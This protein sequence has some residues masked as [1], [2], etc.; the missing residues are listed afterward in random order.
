MFYLSDSSCGDPFRLLANYFL[1]S[2][3]YN[4]DAKRWFQRPNAKSG[5]D[6]RSV[7]K[8]QIAYYPS[9]FYFSQH[10]LEFLSCIMSKLFHS[11]ER[12][13]SAVGT[14]QWPVQCNNIF[15][16]PLNPSLLQ[17]NTKVWENKVIN[18]NIIINFVSNIV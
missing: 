7:G 6:S 4:S 5:E 13:Y 8:L 3:V 17:Y 16:Q 12:S 9:V 15:S 10:C 2:S 18:F 14:A 1:F 11:S